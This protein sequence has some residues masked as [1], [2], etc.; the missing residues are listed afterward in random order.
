MSLHGAL[1]NMAASDTDMADHLMRAVASFDPN[2]IVIS[3]T[4]RAI[5]AAAA[6][7]GLRLVTT[8]LAD[9]AYDDD[10]LLVPRRV[11]GSVIHDPQA[12]LERVR[13]MLADGVVIAHS[14]KH[15]RTRPAS[16][17]LH[18][19]TQGALALAGAIRR[20]IEAGGGSIVP[21]ARQAASCQWRGS[22][23]CSAVGDEA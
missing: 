15:L 19:D 7:H 23:N 3:S 9:R 22:S 11:A 13:R 6:R 14:G 10:G 21:V 4:S 2:L 20:E 18:S 12:V 16:I 5:E 1:G 8:F 17:L